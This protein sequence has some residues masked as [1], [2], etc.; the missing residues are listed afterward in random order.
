M[1]VFLVASIWSAEASSLLSLRASRIMGGLGGGLIEALGPTVVAETFAERQLARA[2]VV[3]VAFLAAGSAV[4]PVI[5][6]LVSQSLGSW[7]WYMRILAI[8]IAVNFAA[9]L[10]MLPETTHDGMGV[11]G[12]I[13]LQDDEEADDKTHQQTVEAAGTNTQYAPEDQATCL[14]RIYLERSFSLKYVKSDWKGAMVRFY[15]PLELVLAPQVLVTTI[16]FGLTIGW[17]VV[18]SILV[19]ME[20]ARP[21]MLW[22]S[23]DVGL[24]SIA[25]LVG[26]IIGLPVGGALA[27]WLSNRSSRA[28]RGDHDPAARL[29]AAMFGALVSPAGCILLGFG[30]QDPSRWVRM[31]FGWG[32]LSVGLTSSANVLL[33]YAVDCL[34]TRAG[35]IGAIVNLTKNCL[36]FGVSYSSVD[37]DEAM[38]PVDQYAIM[39]G[40]LLAA[41]LLVVPLYFFSKI[42]LKKTAPLA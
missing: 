22:D 5:A 15:Q 40:I 33:T 27:D 2:M 9:S 36:A 12:P 28:R 23:L 32:M 11:S 26:L 17:S 38:G 7:R 18:T 31:C 20:Y 3:Y 19:A 37:W 16:V 4:G 1:I 21:P 30:L 13:M 24:A 42:L 35:H 10:V 25:A 14:S 39:G 41:Y 34:P 8:A 6:G 29:P